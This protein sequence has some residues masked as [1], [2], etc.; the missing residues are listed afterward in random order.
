MNMVQS[1][2]KLLPALAV[3]GV[4]VIT[5]WEYAAG[6]AKTLDEFATVL[7]DW[8]GESICLARKPI[9]KDEKVIYRIRRSP[10]EPGRISLIA[11][12]IVEG[13]PV[14]MGTLACDYEKTKQVLS[15]EMTQGVWKFTVEGKKMQGT[16]TLNDKT[17][18][19]RVSVER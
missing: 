10:E 6:Q 5:M 19:R 18:M 16:L 1:R 4:A 13:R 8:K 14:Y 15:C 3:I 17:L 11:D 12:K 7:G 2:T 9:C